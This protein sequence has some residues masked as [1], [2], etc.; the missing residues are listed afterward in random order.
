M[1]LDLD[2]TDRVLGAGP[3]QPPPPAAGPPGA[4]E[5]LR[6]P[7]FRNIWIANMVSNIGAW[8]QGVGAAWEMTQLASSPLFVALISTA[9]TLP[10]F[11]FAYPAGV[12]ADQF[13]RRRF[14]IACQLWMLLSAALLAVLAWSGNLTAWG[15]LILTFWM[16]R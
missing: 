16:L 4:L 8:M 13:D 6:D 15:L 11:F 9:S 7:T 2:D 12:L 3:V 1:S 14:L 10:V 5:P